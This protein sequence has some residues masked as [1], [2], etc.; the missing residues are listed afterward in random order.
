MFENM[1][2]DSP[3]SD[4]L[5]GSDDNN[6]EKYTENENIKENLSYI[7]ILSFYKLCISQN[8]DSHSRQVKYEC[9]KAVRISTF[10]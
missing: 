7:S 9:I 10:N 3:N 1:R 6:R 8:I 5:N 4:F 2:K